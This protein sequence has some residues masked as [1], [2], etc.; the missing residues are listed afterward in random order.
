MKQVV[1]ELTDDLARQIG[2]Y[3]G[4]LQELVLLGLSQLKAQE[5]LALHTAGSS[6]LPAR[7]RSPVSRPEMSRQAYASGI[8]P[9][10]SEQIVEEELA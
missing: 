1:L 3:Q 8:R 9:R 10:W 7:P 4:R 6:P 5:A 2:S